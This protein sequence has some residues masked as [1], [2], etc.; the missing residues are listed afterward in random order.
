MKKT[1]LLSNCRIN[2]YTLEMLAEKKL[3]QVRVVPAMMKLMRFSNGD[4]VTEKDLAYAKT[5]SI[6]LHRERLKKTLDAGDKV[7]GMSSETVM[8]INAVCDLIETHASSAAR[9]AKSL[10]KLH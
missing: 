6:L 1:D 8:K 2:L 9:R 3:S 4:N 10:E 5:D 7:K